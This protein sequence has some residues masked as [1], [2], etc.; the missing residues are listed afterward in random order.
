MPDE[1]T[2]AQ[3]ARAAKQT[4]LT[5]LIR[6]R[7]EAQASKDAQLEVGAE[8]AE[9]EGRSL[10]FLPPNVLDDHINQYTIQINQLIVEIGEDDEDGEEIRKDG[11][12]WDYLFG[13]TIT[14]KNSNT[15]D[16]GRL[17]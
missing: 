4:R 13:Q 17:R 16:A 7:T 10:R 2:P 5:D 1:Q 9:F 8:S 12:G 3:I 15:G 6:R 14:L 11:S